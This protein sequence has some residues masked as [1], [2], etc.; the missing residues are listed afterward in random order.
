MTSWADMLLKL[1]PVA[2]LVL[3]ILLGSFMQGLFRGA[4]GSA[5]RLFIFLWEGVLLVVSLFLAGRIAGAASAPVRNWLMASV[6]V[7]ARQLGALEQAWY[8]FATSV[9]DF[10]MLRFGV[11]FLIAYMLLRFLFSFLSPLAWMLFAGLSG[12]L[13][14]GEKTIPGGRVISRLTGALIGVLHGAARSLVL[15]A[16]LFI[17]VSLFPVAPFTDGIKA[18]PVYKE[19]SAKLLQPVAG[20]VLEKSGPVITKAVGDEFQQIL[21]RKY[22]IID[23]NIPSDIN[24]AAKEIVNG[25]Q[26]DE[27]RAR[28]LYDWLGDRIAY[29]WD[30]ANNYINNGVWKEQT[31]EETFATRKGVCIDT[32]RLY[33]VMARSVGLEVRVVTGQGA[34]GRGG[35]GPHAWN[36]VKLADDGGRWVPLDATWASSGDWFDTPD[37]D[38]THFREV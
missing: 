21:Q 13:K 19:A 37:F 1:E 38:K 5:N 22:E 30:K 23:Y 31:P 26:T 20:Q 10:A 9:R 29:D 16:I 8:T 24:G 28:A 4:S 15:I 36:E 7:P 27:E 3:L 12:G 33:A 11:L 35:F 32:A 18:S 6:E 2:L 34:D 17:Y 14:A 25:K